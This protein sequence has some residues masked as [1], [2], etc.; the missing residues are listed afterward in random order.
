MI[1]T[2]KVI[3][4]FEGSAPISG[5]IRR[6]RSGEIILVDGAAAGDLVSIELD[7]RIFVTDRNLFEASCK[8][9]NSGA[10]PFF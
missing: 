5:Q 6:F 9:I 2:F 1:Q 3:R 8:K 4:D 7:S 10:T